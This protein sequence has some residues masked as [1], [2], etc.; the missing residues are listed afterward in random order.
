[1]PSGHKKGLIEKI[2]M[3]KQAAEA[4]KKLRGKGIPML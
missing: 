1:M 4:K 3:F 2:L